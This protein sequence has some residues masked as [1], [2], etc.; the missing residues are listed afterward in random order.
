ML[1]FGTTPSFKVECAIVRLHFMDRLTLRVALSCCFSLVA[2]LSA[3]SVEAQEAAPPPATPAPQGSVQARDPQSLLRE[4][5]QFYEQLEYDKAIRVL[6]EILQQQGLEPMLRARAFLF[7]GVSFTALGNAENAV[8]SF[9]ELLK[10]RADF[11]MPQGV[12]PSIQAMFKEALKQLNLPEVPPPPTEGPGKKTPSEVKLS[13]KTE[14][15]RLAGSAIPIT[16]TLDDPK[17]H[18]KKLAVRWRLEQQRSFS[19]IDVKLE[20][21]K[22]TFYAVIPGALTGDKK[23]MLF[24]FVEASDQEGGVIAFVGNDDEPLIV[25][26]TVPPSA[27]RRYGWW[28]VGLGGA[29]AIAG[30]IIATLMLTQQHN[31]TNP[32]PDGAANLSVVLK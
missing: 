30:G 4:A 27:F 11:R 18:V 32:I 16:I 28:M 10:I 15:S 9:V 13:A 3:F 20:S 7:L 19:T 26:L 5:E 14:P 23:G 8:A 1:V 17:Q 24:Y 2:M 25:D 31:G 29:A 22:K 21:N 12:S 6:V